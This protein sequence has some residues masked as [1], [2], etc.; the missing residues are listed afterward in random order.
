MSRKLLLS[1]CGVALCFSLQAAPPELKKAQNLL[2]SGNYEAA[3]AQFNAAM[4]SSFD[5]SPA[6][7]KAI[8]SGLATCKAKLKQDRPTQPSSSSA[9]TRRTTS[10][11]H[12]S[13]RQTSPQLAVNGSSTNPV[14]SLS[15]DGGHKRVTISTN[16]GQ[17]FVF[18]VPDWMLVTDVEPNSMTLIWEPNVSPKSREDYFTITAGSKTMNVQVR[19]SGGKSNYL[20]VIGAKYANR[21]NGATISDFG[22]PLYADEMRFLTPCLYYNGPATSETHTVNVKIFNPNGT[23]RTTPY[24]PEGY[25]YK[26]SFEFEPGW[27]QYEYLTGVGRGDASTYDAGLYTIE[28]YIDD[29]FSFSDKLYIN[30]KG[31]DTSYLTFDHNTY[32]ESFFSSDGS[33]NAHTISTDGNWT[34]MDVPEWCK[35]TR[36][37]NRLILTASANTSSSPREGSLT[38]KS[39]NRSMKVALYQAA[40]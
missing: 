33:N 21:R 14:L 24:S 34:T 11:T 7:I 27:D 23:L 19:Q 4:N 29:E 36:Q 20:Q 1:L 3:R 35:A 10:E 22:E 12:A 26:D 38:I 37:G 39:G 18:N 25:T 32:G 2:A 15:G 5:K 16:Q 28:V 13:T 40:R 31:G 9:S 8:K 30:A 17:P 6:D